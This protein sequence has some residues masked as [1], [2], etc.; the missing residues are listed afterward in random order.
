M[1]VTRADLEPY[2]RASAQ[3]YGVP[4]EMFLWQIGK[5]SG[6]DV[7]ARNPNSSAKGVAQFIDGTEKWFGIDAMDPYQAI[8]AAAKY[9][10]MLFKQTGTWE[11]ALTKYGTLHGADNKTKS[12][13]NAALS[14]GNVETQSVA[15]RIL[16]TIKDPYGLY[17]T[18]GKGVVNLTEGAAGAVTGNDESGMVSK[19]IKV[20]SANIG[21][22]VLGIVV[23][24]LAVL[25]NNTVQ[26]MA[27]KAV[28]KK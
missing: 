24:A 25:S 28:F 4:E 19:G 15:D 27:K 8:D 14:G 12:E 20:V 11:G 18:L 7:N 2:A 1:S 10:A 13:F 26:G 17:K 6:W 3:K 22:I 23:I 9:D 16:E 5:E 21:L